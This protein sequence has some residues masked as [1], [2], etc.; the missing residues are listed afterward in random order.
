MSDERESTPDGESIRYAMPL[1][2]RP[3]RR[4]T[5]YRPPVHTGRTVVAVIFILLLIG[6][7]FHYRYTHSHG[8]AVTLNGQ[9]L[10]LLATRR[11][12][13]EAILIVKRRFGAAAIPVLQFKEGP[14]MIRTLPYSLRVTSPQEA[15]KAIAAH[16]TVVI[17]GAA[18]LVDNRPYVLL[19]SKDDAAEALS[20]MQQRGQGGHPGVAT[21]KE[22]VRIEL[23]TWV[24]GD[25]KRKL[26]IL[27]AQDAA[28]LLVH[29]PVPQSHI[30]ELGDNFWKI[31][32]AHSMTV[33]ELKQ[34]NPGVDPAR[35]HKGDIIKLPDQ[36]APV[37]VV[38]I[39]SPRHNTR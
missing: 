16:T 3:R 39:R 35:L 17:S 13:E 19:A 31:A 36:P 5:V 10:A 22:R 11:Q 12:A 29:P 1:R 18:I 37:T 34:L 30:V 8:Y 9:T 6:G 38:V 24:E 2:R 14:L 32:T 21:F 15:A 27:D 7:G 23:Y 4:T 25:E 33:P 28:A 20:L 26:P